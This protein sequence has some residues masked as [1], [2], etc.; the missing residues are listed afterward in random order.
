MRSRR[1]DK[2]SA[3]IWIENGAICKGDSI[4]DFYQ[5]ASILACC[6]NET[7]LSHRWREVG[8]R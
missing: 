5:L 2:I 1:S 8:R 3:S 4:V 7:K 6:L